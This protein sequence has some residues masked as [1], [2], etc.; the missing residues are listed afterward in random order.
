MVILAAEG[1]WGGG[2]ADNKTTTPHCYAILHVAT[3]ARVCPTQIAF[4][5]GWLRRLAS[6]DRAADGEISN[7]S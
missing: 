1:K 5:L 7:H 6:N 4:Y 3:L 2:L